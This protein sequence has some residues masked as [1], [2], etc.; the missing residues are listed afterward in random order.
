MA[1]Q[2]TSRSAVGWTWFGAIMMWLVGGFHAIA[3]LVGLFDEGFYAEVTEYTFRFDL[4]TRSW[5]HLVIGVV[6]AA[7]GFGV[8]A[9]RTWARTIGV[10]LAGISILANF[11]W[12]PIYPVWSIATMAAAFFVI[13]ALVMRG[14]D[15]ARAWAE[16]STDPDVGRFFDEHRV[17]G[18]PMAGH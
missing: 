1:Q 10:I 3:G 8:L 18:D 11:A 7:A 2:E 6:I 14:E 4:A 15:A 5:V 17:A 13:W 9:G 12:L 16:Q